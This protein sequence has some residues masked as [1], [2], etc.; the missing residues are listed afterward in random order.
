[1]N[2]QKRCSWAG[3]DPRMIAYHDDEWGTPVHD[4][5]KFF[6]FLVLEGAQAGLSW[7]TIL[8]KREGYRGAFAGFDPAKEEHPNAVGA[9]TIRNDGSQPKQLTTVS[10]AMTM[11]S[12]MRTK[13]ITAGSAFSA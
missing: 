6:E 10:T 13:C 3:G 5:S 8:D 9:G 2:K 7:K 11:A 12:P 4:D 1:M